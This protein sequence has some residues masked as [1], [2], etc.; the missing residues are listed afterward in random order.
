MNIRKYKF[1][2]KLSNLPYVEAI[3]LYGSRARGDNQDMSDID[4]AIFSPKVDASIQR[5]E[6]TVELFWK[7][8]KR[9]I[10]SL[11]REVNFPKEVLQEAYLS[12]MI[13]DEK[14]WLC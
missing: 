5:F 8:L 14:I 2:S 1:F 4:I 13:E 3:W 12:K 10:I 11:G 9:S 6:F 7:L